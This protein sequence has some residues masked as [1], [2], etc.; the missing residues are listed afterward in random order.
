MGLPTASQNQRKL[1]GYVAS[2]PPPPPRPM[3]RA[4]WGSLWREF[5]S[6]GAAT[7]KALLLEQVSCTS[8]EGGT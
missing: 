7:K 2:S 5:R 1:K 8:A 6:H 4:G 3:E